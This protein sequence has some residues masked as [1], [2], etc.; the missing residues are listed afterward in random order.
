MKVP[1]VHGLVR[2]IDPR[3]TQKLEQESPRPSRTEPSNADGDS[4]DIQ[5]SSKISNISSL[6]TDESE[7][8][9]E[10]MSTERRAEI[11]SRVNK[12]FYNEPNASNATAEGILD[13]YSR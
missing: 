8:G 1:D 13:F 2:S 6:I 9:T 5:L 11:L 10:P 12:G 3:G 4:L 7:V